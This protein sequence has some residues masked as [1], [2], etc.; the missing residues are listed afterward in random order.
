[1]SLEALVFSGGAA[2]MALELVGSRVLAPSFGNSIFVWGSL[3]GV[4]MTALSGGYYL[5]GR[6]ADRWPSKRLL[7]VIIFAAG[8]WVAVLPSFSGPFTA[9][10]AGLGMGPKAG[11]LTAAGA[12][13]TGPSLLLGTLSP[14]ALKLRTKDL[15][16][17]GNTAG[18]LYAVS[19]VGSIAGTLTTA[20]WLV[21]A[22]S[23][24]M[25]LAALGV[26]LGLLGG[27]DLILASRRRALTGAS[28]ALLLAGVTAI[29]PL[30][31]PL[32]ASVL[33]EKVIFDRET[34][35]HHVRVVDV[36]DSRFLRFD[37]SWQSGMYRSDPLRPR[38]LYTDFFNL[39][40]L[41]QPEPRRALFIGLGGGSAVKSFLADHP[42]L[43]IDVAEID[44]AVIEVARR[45]FAVPED[46]QR[47]AVK[48]EDGRLFLRAASGGYD[49]IVLDA[50]YA[51]AVP[52]H[53]FTQEFFR[54]ARERLSPGGV[55][56]I[57]VVASLEGRQSHLFRSVYRTLTTVFS[58]VYPFAVPLSAAERPDGLDRQ[59]QRNIIIFTTND[60][61]AYDA[62]ELKAVAAELD[63]SGAGK[64]KTLGAYAEGLQDATSVE[65]ADVPVLSDDY[66]P[67]DALLHLR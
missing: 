46:G 4:F 55:L 12:L 27:I 37:N 57:N 22:F 52:F 17:V 32:A 41:W 62:A 47:L 48:A 50:Y 20:F 5:G 21:P 28:L 15:K 30:R 61:R 24:R 38:F 8:A 11:P 35:Y 31:G 51:D 10:V 65:T 56:A 60:G 58:R 49:L 36:G 1:M 7:A 44:P 40:R 53:L 63:E 34:L 25:I 54:L 6:L 19:T 2:L 42:R 3:I 16:A 43:S 67:V 29:G 59:G 18:A 13:F 23:V 26:F 64:T 39:A 9:W 14:F 66:A 45:Y 33:G